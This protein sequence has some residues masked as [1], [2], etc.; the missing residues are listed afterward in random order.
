MRKSREYTAEFKAEA[1]RLVRQKNRTAAEVA[2]ALGIPATVLRY[3]IAQKVPPAPILEPRGPEALEVENRRLR[4]MVAR[5]EEERD[6]LKKAAAYF[7]N[8]S[9]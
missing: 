1:L 4:R 8:A 6:I 5:L 2:R 3:W 7:A 9:R